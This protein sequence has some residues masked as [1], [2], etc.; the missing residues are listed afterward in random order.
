MKE[1]QAKYLE[2]I[3][4]VKK[5]IREKELQAGDKLNSENELSAIFG[6][7]RQTIRHAVGIL[8]EEGIVD[9]IQGSGTYISDNRLANLENKTRVAVVTTYV[10]SYI[11]PK[12]IQGIERVLTGQGYS[13]QIAFTGN[14]VEKER[15]VLNDII[16][17][18][19]VAGIIIEATKSGLPNPNLPV[20][21]QLLRAQIPVLFIN[22]YYPQLKAPHVTMNDLQAAARA[23]EYLIQKG[24]KKIGA[25]LKNDDGQGLLRYQG[26]CS[27]MDAAGLPVEDKSLVWLDTYDVQ[28][29]D[30]CKDYI[31]NRISGCTAILAYNDQVA[32][33]LIQTLGEKGKKVPQ[34]YSVI[35]IDDSDLALHCEV[36]IT[37]VPHPT[38]KLG[39][40]AALNLIACMK[41]ETM[42]ATVEFPS[43]IVERESV[44]TL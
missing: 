20:Y 29:M 4:W 34:D 27:A 12:T 43:E 16:S 17:R 6:L 28:N 8:E 38:D 11:F 22:S 31:Y 40:Q 3:E 15:M 25:V 30:T 41:M 32:F 1:N 2:V 44:R 42:D 21:R 13:V 37:S 10:D 39:E 33:D 35:G 7:S 9:R 24:H 23:V 18:D 26:Y 36:P 14:S 5:R 19:D